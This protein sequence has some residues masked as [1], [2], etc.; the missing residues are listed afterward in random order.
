MGANSSD[1]LNRARD[2]KEGA[3]DRGG[4]ATSV[5]GQVPGGLF[6]IDDDRLMFS[7]FKMAHT[8]SATHCS[9]ALIGVGS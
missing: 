2:D 3:A 4:P 7:A 5:S 8:K 9:L 1:P 6:T